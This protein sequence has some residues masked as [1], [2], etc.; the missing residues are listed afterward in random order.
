MLNH[1]NI[2]ISYHGNEISNIIKNYNFSFSKKIA[3]KL[4]LNIMF[5]FLNWLLFFDNKYI[6]LKE[7]FMIYDYKPH[8]TNKKESW[9]LRSV[10]IK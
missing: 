10:S 6:T 2:Q 4:R 7:Y 8:F 5:K 9:W 3:I 1:K